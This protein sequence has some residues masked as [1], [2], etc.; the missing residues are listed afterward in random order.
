MRNAS[1]PY[2]PAVTITDIADYLSNTY[3]EQT[4]TEARHWGAS[5]ITFNVQAL[6][7]ARAALARIAFQ[8]WS[9]V[10]NLT[11]VETTGAALIT[12]GD[13]DPN[14]AYASSTLFG[15]VLSSSSINVSSDW[16]GG[17]DAVDSYTLQTFIHEI[18]HAIGLGHSGPY[19]GSAAYGVDN[20][21]ANDSWHLSIMSYM[22]QGDA[23]TGSYRFVLTPEIADILAVQ[24]YY[25]APT[26][27]RTGDT[28]Y[29][30]GSTGGS[31]YDF[32]TYSQAPALTIF[33]SGG[34]DTLRVQSDPTYRSAG[35]QLLQHRRSDRQ[36][37][38]LHDDRHREC[39]RRVRQRHDCRQRRRQQARRRRRQRFSRRRGGHRHSR[40]FRGDPCR[41]GQPRGWDC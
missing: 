34:N 35:R 39:G 33:D 8:S 12:L 23:G 19:N 7:P 9:D 36:H 18:G 5:T 20:A 32:A 38:R 40:L 1:T 4:G 37:R 3:W 41:D 21:Y 27:T 28:V 14:S 30:H 29:G 26:T 16:F 31:L 17:D 24:R 2:F 6:E 10:C 25:G 15:S 13:S 22:D 11:F